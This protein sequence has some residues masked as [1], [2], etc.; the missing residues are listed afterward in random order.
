[1]TIKR[2]TLSL[3][4]LA[5]LLSAFPAQAAGNLSL[6]QAL[7]RATLAGADAQRIEI[8]PDELADYDFAN[9]GDPFE[10]S[11]GSKLI[12]VQREAAKKEFT[13]LDSG[14]PWNYI[15]GFPD[16]FT[17][18]DVGEPR[19]WLRADLMS[20]LSPDFRAESLAKADFIV[21]AE[22]LYDWTGTLTET[23][24]E[25]N[26]SDGE[27]PDWVTTP[28]ELEQYIASHQPVISSIT[29]YPK[30]SVLSLISIFNV[31]TKVC[32]YLAADYTDV[33][34]FARN[35]EAADLWDEMTDLEVL[36]S[37]FED[38]ALTLQPSLFCYL[39]DLYEESATIISSEGISYWR[40]CINNGYQ[41]AA[42][43]SMEEV[44]WRT[45][46]KL[47]AL[48]GD[49]DHQRM[50]DMI[51]QSGSRDMLNT[52]VSYFNYSGIEMEIETIGAQ[53]LYLAQADP[54]WF[55]SNL[56]EIVDIFSD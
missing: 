54:E 13:A 17:G 31:K 22:T 16:D 8:N 39:L 2:L 3:L 5:L 51:I 48:D 28:E 53:E 11:T 40:Q 56:L 12:I 49:P 19:V 43:T 55:E 27:I 29:Y 10:G 44:Y 26:D 18:V 30:F 52:A 32:E 33:M 15:E 23:E 9:Q 35:P 45:A 50:F 37:F 38:G 47:S 4:A 24:Y 25:K 36:L 7:A 21:I 20:Q 42:L 34:R 1:M 46:S 41:R 6:D 14:Y